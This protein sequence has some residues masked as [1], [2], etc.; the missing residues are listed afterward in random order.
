[1][2]LLALLRNRPLASAGCQCFGALVACALS[3]CALMHED[4]KPIAEIPPRQ[5]RLADDIHLAR[6]GWP[7][8]RWWTGYHDPQLDAFI[9][10]ALTDAPTMAIARGR[11]DQARAQVELVKSGTSLQAAAS[12]AVN[13]ERVSSN[14]FLSAYAS[15]NPFLGATGPWYTEGIVGV[16]ASYQFDI[17][18]KQRDQISASIGVQNARLAEQAAVELEV[19]TDVAQ[20]Y[21]GIQTTLQTVDLLQQAHEIVAATVEAHAARASR[22]LEPDTYTQQARAQQL[23]IEGQLTE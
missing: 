8:A 17:W 12:A 14:G 16:G 3:G 2:S 13:R 23:A 22:G 18:G 1:M 15:T 11:V 10:Q 9:D 5:V 21:Y 19:S 7:S 4:S 6:E 20:L